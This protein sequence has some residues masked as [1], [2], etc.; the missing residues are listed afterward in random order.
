MML[1]WAVSVIILLLTASCMSVQHAEADLQHQVDVLST[2]Y[3]ISPPVIRWQE[4]HPSIL[5]KAQCGPRG[6]V[7]LL[8]SCL[9]NERAWVLHAVLLHEYA[10]VLDYAD[11]GIMSAHGDSWRQAL[12]LLGRPDIQEVAPPG[13]CAYGSRNDH[14][15]N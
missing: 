10:H 14:D 7:I 8:S 11:N 4:L 6:C 9:Q 12:E 13:W 1:R 15:N 5:G 2:E 3:G